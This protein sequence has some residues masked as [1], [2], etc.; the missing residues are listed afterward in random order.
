MKR[1]E[2]SDSIPNSNALSAYKAA[3]KAVKESVDDWDARYHLQQTSFD[4]NTLPA[5][6]STPQ[7]HDISAD[8]LKRRTVHDYKRAWIYRQLLAPNCV[9]GRLKGLESQQLELMNILE[10]TLVQNQ[11]N[12]VLLV[13]YRGCGKSA[14]LRSVLADLKKKHHPLGNHFC[15]IYLNGQIQ[16][17]D[18]MA[19]KEIMRQLQ[20]D[21]QRYEDKTSRQFTDEVAA[22]VNLLKEGRYSKLPVFFILDEF[23]MFAQNNGRQTLLYLLGDLLQDKS[24]QIGIVG[25]TCRVDAHHLLEKRIRSRMSYR[26]IIVSH[27]LTVDLLKEAIQ[28]SLCLPDIT[29]SECKSAETEETVS[30]RN[31]E[32]PDPNKI[33]RR[34]ILEHNGH[35]GEFLNSSILTRKLQHI[36]ASGR[37]MRWIN[38][39]LSLT[40]RKWTYESD[41]ARPEIFVESCDYLGRDLVMLSFQSCS[42]AEF[43]LIATMIQLESEETVSYSFRSIWS[44]YQAYMKANESDSIDN[45]TKNH[46]FAVFETLLLNRQIIKLANGNLGTYRKHTELLLKQ[47]EHV[48][49]AIAGH[50]AR[51]VLTKCKL[52]TWLGD[53]VKKGG[54]AFTW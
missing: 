30:S 27:L 52:P 37:D 23:H 25:L 6:L 26:H 31:F 17:D 16:T 13:G 48:R 44:T 28:E 47:T 29:E 43:A 2:R 40:L 3:V 36:H 22:I 46:M 50:R 24:I 42:I 12:A 35:V 41:F 21:F 32:P 49:L 54:V 9:P 10:T 53:W 4:R 14:I 15:E 8:E 34:D 1:K 7:Y 19:I 33:S 38:N 20:A 45:F 11:N 5:A 51:D 18:S 39:A